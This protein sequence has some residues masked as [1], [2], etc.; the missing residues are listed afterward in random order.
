MLGCGVVLAVFLL[1]LAGA[2][3]LLDSKTQ[4]LQQQHVS[5]TPAPMSDDILHVDIDDGALQRIGRW[6]WTRTLIAG[7]I[8]A[9]ADAGVGR[10]L[11]P[12][13]QKLHFA[14][15]LWV[16]PGLR[17]RAAAQCARLAEQS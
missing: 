6:P 4:D 13:R 3:Q 9:L 7:C 15:L 17:R 10:P 16:G 12:L 5:R 2:F 1:D 14:K 11:E 8:D